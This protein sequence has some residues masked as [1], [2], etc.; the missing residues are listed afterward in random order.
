[1]FSWTTLGWRMACLGTSRTQ[2]R[3]LRPA[4]QRTRSTP[5]SSTTLRVYYGEEN[6]LENAITH[7]KRAFELRANVLPGEKMPD[8]LQDDSF[9]RFRTNEQF[10][11]VAKSLSQ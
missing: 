7:L 1:M 2:N 4:L 11:T 9:Q 8:P 10:I 6:D 5:S 3:Y